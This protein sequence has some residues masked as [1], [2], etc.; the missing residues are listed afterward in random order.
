MKGRRGG[1]GV[2]VSK[3]EGERVREGR[4]VGRV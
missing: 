3:V 1:I 4:E 2:Q